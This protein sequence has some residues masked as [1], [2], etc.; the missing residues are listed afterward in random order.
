NMFT[1]KQ[2]SKTELNVVADLL[3]KNPTLK[4][5][6]GGHTDNTGSEE[7]NRILSENRAKSVAD[8]LISKGVPPAR[9]TFKGYASSRPVADNSTEQ[10][11]AL[12]RRTELRVLEI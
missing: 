6:I 10:G 1:L 7:N 2:A 9:I 4:V 8:Y 3:L 11:R 12:N 5:E